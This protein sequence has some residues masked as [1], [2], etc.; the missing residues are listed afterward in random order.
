MKFKETNFKTQTCSKSKE[1]KLSLPPP[2]AEKK[3]KAFS[4]D[5]MKAKAF[6]A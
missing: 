4:H 6:K 5:T 1:Q 3:A 2:L